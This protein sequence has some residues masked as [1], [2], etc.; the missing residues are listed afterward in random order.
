[1]SNSELENIEL[2]EY[3]DLGSLIGMPDD[4]DKANIRRI[5][6]K[7]EKQYPGR[8]QHSIAEARKELEQST[9]GIWNKFSDHGVVEQETYR[10]RIL[11]LPEGLHQRIEKYMP[12]IFRDR[13]HLA[14]FIKNF[15]ELLVPKK[16]EPRRGFHKS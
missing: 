5:I 12:S 1:M 8:V 6:L 10:A 9:G 15:P 13:K 3:K 14:W 7:Y 4:E 16:Y 2:N 11:E